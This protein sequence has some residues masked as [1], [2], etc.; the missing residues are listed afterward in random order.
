MSMK[1]RIRKIAQILWTAF[2]MAGVLEIAV[3]SWADPL[4]FHLGSWVPD[5]AVTAYS[6]MF[7][8]FWGVL[9]AT[10]GL[11]RWLMSTPARTKI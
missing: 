10:I 5:N 8:V 7:L 11:N 3:F 6:V 4:A 1:R 9:V 2:L